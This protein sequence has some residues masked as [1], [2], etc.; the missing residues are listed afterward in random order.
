VEQRE[1]FPGDL[2]RQPRQACDV[3]T[4]PRQAGDKPF[5]DGIPEANHDD[6]H[7]SSNL[8]NRLKRWRCVHNNHVDGKANQ[9]GR[10][11]RQ[12]PNLPA[13]ESELDGNVLP[14]DV[15]ELTQP[16]PK[17]VDFCRGSAVEQE[18]DPIHLPGLR[19]RRRAARRAPR[20]ARENVRRSIT[21]SPVGPRQ[22]RRQI[23]SPSALAVLRLMTNS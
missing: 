14:F 8:S 13:R 10:K 20:P 19:H 3:P 23:I 16:L 22:H 17:G 7:R 5:G 4:W 1:P 21:G 12:S 11:L 9:F 15:P 18:P 6:R 2:G